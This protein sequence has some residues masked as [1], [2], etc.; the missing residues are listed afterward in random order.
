MRTAMK[1]VASSDT[2]VRDTERREMQAHNLSF[3]Q[4]T[5]GGA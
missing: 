2:V 4:F 3:I 1:T 5:S